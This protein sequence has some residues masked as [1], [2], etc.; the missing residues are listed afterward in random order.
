[1]TDFS[2]EHRQLIDAVAERPG[3]QIA[4]AT[5]A[6]DHDGQPMEGYRAHDAAVAG[7]KPAVLIVHDWT[8]LREY[9]KA[10]AHMLARLG[11]FAFCADVY[12]A[13]R[14]F[15]DHDYQGASGEAGKYYGD[16]ELLRGRVRA[17]YDELAG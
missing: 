3:A 7:P 10:R 17:A 11:Y 9:P 14:R 16:L 15:E 8:G 12:G 5:V 13:G 2:A 1:M 4:E 6:Y